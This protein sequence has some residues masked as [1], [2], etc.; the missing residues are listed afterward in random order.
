MA[1][2]LDQVQARHGGVRRRLS[3]HGFAA[4]DSR[5]LRSWLLAA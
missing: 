5:A 3:G 4:D 2:F 1:A